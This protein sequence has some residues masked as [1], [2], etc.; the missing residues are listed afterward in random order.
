MWYYK[1]HSSLCES[2]LGLGESQQF[3]QT[4]QC[5]RRQE[6]FIDLTILA[7]S[8]FRLWNN[9]TVSLFFIHC[10]SASLSHLQRR[11]HH[12]VVFTR[13][14]KF[15]R[16]AD[17]C[18]ILPCLKCT[19]A[20]QNFQ[21]TYPQKISS[22]KEKTEQVLKIRRC[23]LPRNLWTCWTVFITSRDSLGVHKVEIKLRSAIFLLPPLHSWT[24]L[25]CFKFTLI[26]MR[27]SGWIKVP[28]E[29][30]CSLVAAILCTRRTSPYF[31]GKVPKEHTKAKQIDSQ[32]KV[33]DLLESCLCGESCMWKLSTDGGRGRFGGGIQTADD[34]VCI[35]RTLAPATWCSGILNVKFTRTA[36]CAAYAIVCV[37][38]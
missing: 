9:S 7:V 11:S 24:C 1:T 22:W 31:S 8:S 6:I 37:F 17:S 33:F 28:W 13:K 18:L 36:S 32:V 30:F 38:L 15:F 5:H 21:S 2:G 35:V 19:D 14:K 20:H 29:A 12:I 16:A 34:F 3:V 26:M 10:F 23:S 27:N 25:G 4:F